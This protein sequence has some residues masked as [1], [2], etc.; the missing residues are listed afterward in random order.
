MVVACIV[1]MIP[2]LV[3]FL[4][5]VFA[6]ADAYK[7]IYFILTLNGKIEPAELL[8][9]PDTYDLYFKSYVTFW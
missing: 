1:R 3:I 9:D 8:E 2:F 6:F 5:G 4:V 7:S